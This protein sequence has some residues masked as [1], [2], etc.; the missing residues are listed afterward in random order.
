MSGIQENQMLE[1]AP[2]AIVLIGIEKSLSKAA[3]RSRKFREGHPDYD[4]KWRMGN[5]EK[6]REQS[7]DYYANHLTEQRIRCDK[8]NRKVRMENP[9]KV[10]EWGRNE[11]KTPQGIFHSYKG[12]AKKRKIIF[13]ISVEQFSTFIGKPCMYC[14]DIAKGV[15][16]IENSKGYVME[17]LGSCCGKCNHMKR[18]WSEKEFIDH[19]KKIVE[20]YSRSK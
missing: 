19:C 16:R 3:I 5:R 15:D 1:F 13:S 10:K 4:A 20:N 11:S 14:G 17:N 7:N 12:G 6:I 8:K 9:E 2:N 18:Q